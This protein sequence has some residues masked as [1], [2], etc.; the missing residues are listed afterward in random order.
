MNNKKQTIFCCQCGKDVSAK[1]TNGSECYK[2]RQDLHELPFWKCDTCGNFVGCHHKSNT[3]T[4][5]L[6]CI[7][8][9][10]IKEE[11]KKIHAIIDPIWKN[12]M[13]S[14]SEIYKLLSKKLQREYHTADLRTQEEC[15]M[16]LD[17]LETFKENK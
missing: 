11:R 16:V 4:K 5:P 7:P 9:K 8:S 1:L 3:P 15:K 6:G 13:T 10:V 17:F 14:R 12:G 2:H